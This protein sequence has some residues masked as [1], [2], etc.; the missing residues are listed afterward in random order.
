MI[1]RFRAAGQG[2]HV[3][4]NFLFRFV[5]CYTVVVDMDPSGSASGN[6]WGMLPAGCGLR[7]LALA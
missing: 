4:D 1:Y 5:V 2:N 3:V 7:G 6:G